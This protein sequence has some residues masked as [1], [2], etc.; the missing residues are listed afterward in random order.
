MKAM[1]DRAAKKLGP[2][3]DGLKR[4]PV[5]YRALGLIVTL[6]LYLGGLLL[7]EL[8]SIGTHVPVALVGIYFLPAVLRAWLLL[9]W[10]VREEIRGVR[11]RTER[12]A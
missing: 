10:A 11:A 4:V 12:H 5:L 8:V 6:A 9:Y 7:V 2:V 3:A 1:F